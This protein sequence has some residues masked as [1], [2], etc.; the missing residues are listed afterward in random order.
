MSCAGVFF[1]LVFSGFD[2]KTLEIGEYIILLLSKLSVL[3]FILL[4][5]YRLTCNFLLI[6]LCNF[7]LKPFNEL[8]I[9]QFLKKYIRKHNDQ[10]K[11]AYIVEIHNNTCKDS[12]KLSK[13]ELEELYL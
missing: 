8:F 11:I 13:T 4:L 3:L 12:Q 5:I 1:L 10:S 9:K 6:P 2:K 7:I